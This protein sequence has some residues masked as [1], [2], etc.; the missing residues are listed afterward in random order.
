MASGRDEWLIGGRWYEPIWASSPDGFALE[1]SDIA[2]APARGLVLE[3][4]R[5]DDSGETTVTCYAADGLP[6][7]LIEKFVGKARDR[8]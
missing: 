3:A 2:P 4:Y 7:A 1:L 8:L 6:L 5:S